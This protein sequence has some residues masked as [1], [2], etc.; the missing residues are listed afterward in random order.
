MLVTRLVHKLCSQV[1]FS[2][3]TNYDSLSHW[4]TLNALE[5]FINSCGKYHWHFEYHISG[6]QFGIKNYQF[7]AEKKNIIAMILDLLHIF[8]MIF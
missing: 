1:I 7:T 5:I 6:S 2:T 4:H 8:E 3:Q